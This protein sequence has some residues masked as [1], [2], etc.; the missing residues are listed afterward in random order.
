[1]FNTKFV[2][3]LKVINKVTNGI[4]LNYPVTVGK[5]DCS[6]IGFKFDISQFDDS[7]FDS[8]VGFVDLASFLNV[9]SLVEEPEVEY[10]EGVVTVKDKE[11]T[12]RYI[13]S[14]VDMIS[15]YQFSPKQFEIMEGI[16]SVVEI[17]LTANDIR[18]IKAAKASF[19]ELNTIV[20]NAS[21][22][23]TIA[24]TQVGKFNLSSNS[25]VIN[26]DIVSEKNFSVN[27]SIDTFNKIPVV[28]YTIK[29]KYNPDKNQYRLLLTADNIPG[30]ELFVSTIVF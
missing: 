9:F 23:V 15:Q 29:V 14:A 5:T 2:D 4:V 18:K 17:P 11:T 24:L 30:F 26:K 12:I 16:P 21:E 1:M 7:A 27:M 6:D 22:Q 13:T 3:F 25:F 8:A 19:K 20:L 28:D 10:S